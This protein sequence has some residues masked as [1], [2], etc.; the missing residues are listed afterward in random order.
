[1]SLRTKSYLAFYDMDGTILCENSATHM[2]RELRSRGLMNSVQ[3]Q[4]AL[5]SSLLYK[6]GL[7]NPA[8]MVKRML[9]WTEGF[10]AEM[11]QQLGREIYEARIS[12][13]FRHAVLNSIAKH[14]AQN[15][16]IVVLSSALCPICR[17][18]AEELSADALICSALGQR[19]GQL[20][21]TLEGKLVFGPEKQVQMQNFCEENEQHA[22]QAWYY[23]DS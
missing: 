3:V 7:G 22:S 15:A 19:N 12:K 4:R 5:L 20:T 21:G 10:E 6:L 18:V 1:M 9:T 13:L 8:G 11:I 16:G 23:G 17:P 2:V 14:R